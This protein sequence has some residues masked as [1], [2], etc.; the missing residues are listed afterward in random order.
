MADLSLAPAFL[1]AGAV[2]FTIDAGRW[3]R[4]AAWLDRVEADTP[5]GP[6]NA[7]AR[8]LMR[9]PI[10]HQRERLPE[11][12]FTPTDRSWMGAE[13]RRGRWECDRGETLGC[14]VRAPVSHCGRSPVDR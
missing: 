7:M 13:A 2:G 10:Q 3:P 9:T 6:L 11:F 5:L 4:L 14:R 8:A 1:N 12:G